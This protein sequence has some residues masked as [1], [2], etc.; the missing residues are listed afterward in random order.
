MA[1]GLV[2]W[3][4]HVV[5]TAPTDLGKNASRPT[6]GGDCRDLAFNQGVL[7]SNPSGLTKGS[8]VSG[9]ASFHF[10]NGS[11][12]EIRVSMFLA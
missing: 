9:A 6:H 11:R 2:Q 3:E 7:G 4:A 12:A 5:K 10:N 8:S 1:R